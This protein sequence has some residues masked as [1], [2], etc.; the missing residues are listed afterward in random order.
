MSTTESTTEPVETL[1]LVS[2]IIEHDGGIPAPTAIG[3]VGANAVVIQP[4][5]R[6]YDR[7]GWTLLADVHLGNIEAKVA[8]SLLRDIAEQLDGM[9]GEAVSD[10]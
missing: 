8:A 7:E 5:G 10:D 6:E 1:R 3:L 9:D 4:T 2:S